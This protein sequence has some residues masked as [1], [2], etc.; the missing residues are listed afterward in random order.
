MKLV[1]RC[2]NLNDLS[3]SLGMLAR[4]PHTYVSS[5]SNKSRI[6]T[7]KSGK[8]I[9][10][11]PDH[12]DHKN[13]NRQDHIDAYFAHAGEATKA[14]DSKAIKRHKEHMQAHWQSSMTAVRKSYEDVSDLFKSTSSVIGKTKSG[15]K[16]LHSRHGHEH[17]S[18]SDF[19]HDDHHDAA[20][21]HH[22]HAM[23]KLSKMMKHGG[24]KEKKEFHAHAKSAHGHAKLSMKDE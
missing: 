8:A 4:K 12:T 9:H 3:K 5:G 22:A 2:G 11:T 18:Y 20:H 21:R 10:S 19:T 16:I 17:P 15:K 7:T 13:F 14:F 6:G 24:M 1:I 23:K